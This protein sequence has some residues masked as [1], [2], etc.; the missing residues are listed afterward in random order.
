MQNNKSLG[1]KYLLE[2]IKVIHELL[3][4]LLWYHIVSHEGISNIKFILSSF[5]TGAHIFESRFYFC[6]ACINCW[7]FYEIQHININ[8]VSV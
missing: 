5:A 6:I 7:N 3:N 1:L 8:Q 2:I 4:V